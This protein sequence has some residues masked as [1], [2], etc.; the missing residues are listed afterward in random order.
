MDVFSAGFE[1]QSHGRKPAQ[2]VG[3]SRLS[4][5]N[6]NRVRYGYRIRREVFRPTFQ[7]VLEIR[8]ADFLFELPNELNVDG[9]AL[10]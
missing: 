9:Y 7:E 6:P 2:S 3:H 8:A 5:G 1:N 4:T 10:L